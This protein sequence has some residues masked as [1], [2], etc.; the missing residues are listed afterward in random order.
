[1]FGALDYKSFLVVFDYK[2]GEFES[3]SCEC[4]RNNRN[5]KLTLPEAPISRATPSG[6]QLRLS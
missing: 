3:F 5:A 1:M 4:L 2:P 6:H